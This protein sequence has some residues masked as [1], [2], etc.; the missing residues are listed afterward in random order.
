MEKTINIGG[1]EVRFRASALTPRIYRAKT[2]RDMFTDI[3]TLE[4]AIGVAA[5][6]HE[7]LPPSA[8]TIFED[9]AFTLAKQA[10]ASIP[11]TADEWLDTFDIFD[12]YVVLPQIL[13][14]WRTNMATTAKAKKK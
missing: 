5:E 4:M 13:S 3:A 6:K 12:I 8:L 7:A 9:V 10:D 1:R 14:V 2:G 11:A